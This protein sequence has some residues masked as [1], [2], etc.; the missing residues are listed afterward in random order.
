MDQKMN[1]TKILKSKVHPDLKLMAIIHFTKFR[2]TN[3]DTNM[4][5]WIFIFIKLKMDFIKLEM[6]LVM[7]MLIIQVI[8]MIYSTQPG[9]E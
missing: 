1:F 7:K 5:S 4:K 8:Q 9:L 2:M 3:L 6:N